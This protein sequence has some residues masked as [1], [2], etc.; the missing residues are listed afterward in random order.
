MSDVE[1]A[2]VEGSP[3]DPP[4]TG[5]YD[6]VI[7]DNPAEPLLG[8]TIVATRAA[9]RDERRSWFGSLLAGWNVAGLWALITAGAA[10]LLAEGVAWLGALAG[11][12]TS[13]AAAVTRTGG[14]LFLWFHGIGLSIAPPSAGFGGPGAAILQNVA[15]TLSLTLM[16]GTIFVLVLLGHAGRKVADAAGGAAWVR[17]LHGMK[18][19]LPYGAV[20]LLLSLAESFTLRLPGSSFPGVDVAGVSIHPVY[21]E[22]FLWPA[23]LG[24]LGGFVGGLRSTPDSDRTTATR[25]LRGAVSGAGAM[26]AFALALSF[27][28]LLILAALHPDATRS[29]MNGMFGRGTT[30]GLALLTLNVLALPNLCVWLLVPAMGSCVGGHVTYGGA[31]FSSCLVSYA[32]VATPAALRGIE[33]LGPF[34]TDPRQ[35]PRPA[36]G[37]LAFM[38]IPLAAAALGGYQASRRAVAGTRSWAAGVG[39]LAAG[40]F[41]FLVAVACLLAAL[42]L[43]VHGVRG[44]E[45]GGRPLGTATLWLGPAPLQG[46]LF[47]LAWGVLGGALGG[48]LAGKAGDL[49]TVPADTEI[50]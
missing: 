49:Q 22:A 2:E 6:A 19:A 50:G 30:R 40:G 36:T 32:H 15:V 12:A 35:L 39:V 44:L 13:H 47:G 33:T 43:Q 27:L 10:L 9:R 4:P 31:T 18:I 24:L 11:G 29:Y 8:E 1:H 17:G 3:A 16:T 28:G 45:G 38:A 37:Y 46:A 26:M 14:A 34:A 25:L 48:F 7:A 21:L 42:I 23:L 5:E 41:A 20:C